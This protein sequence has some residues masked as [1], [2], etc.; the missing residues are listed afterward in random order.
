MTVGLEAPKWNSWALSGVADRDLQ[1]A[2][3]VAI[4]KWPRG[5]VFNGLQRFLI[6]LVSRLDEKLSH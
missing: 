5:F 4:R 2:V 3:F 6:V 1:S